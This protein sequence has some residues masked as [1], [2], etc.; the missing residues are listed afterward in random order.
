MLL[1]SRLPL[2][3][4]ALALA[5]AGAAFA[6]S[7]LA[8]G[9]GGGAASEGALPKGKD[10]APLVVGKEVGKDIP[11]IQLSWVLND[12]GRS[13][14]ADHRGEVVIVDLW[15]TTCGP[16][17]GLIP[18]FTKEQEEM[19]R[20]GLVIFGITGESKDVLS[21]FLATGNTAAIGYKM[22]SGSS[23]GMQSPGTVPYCFVVAADGKVAWQGH[24][25]P[26]SKLVEAELKKVKAPT[27]E[28]REARA[29]KVLA[30]AEAL[31]GERKVLQAVQ[32]LDR[33]AKEHAGTE[34]AKTAAERSAVLARDSAAELAAQKALEKI[35]GGI[36]YPKEKLSRKD[37][38]ARLVQI[39]ALLKKQGEACPGMK[40]IAEYWAGVLKVD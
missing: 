9:D 21:K 14:V 8:G 5:A 24:G 28:E 11:D 3:L 25:A 39:E 36:E 38:Q 17:R 27:A 16:C 4:P 10:G 18:S 2:L 34:A 12:D 1:R 6:P 20:K 30:R 37:R 23:G 35:L 22:A 40:E 31:A 33:I 7:V 19:G 26:P 15:A 29:A 32:L 13:T